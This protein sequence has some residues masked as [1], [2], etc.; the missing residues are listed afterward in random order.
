MKCFDQ[1]CACLLKKTFW[2]VNYVP[3]N[4]FTPLFRPVDAYDAVYK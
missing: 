4:G 2:N 3:V 1:V